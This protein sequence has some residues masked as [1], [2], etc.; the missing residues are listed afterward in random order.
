MC[1]V[2]IPV[3]V[4]F[5]YQSSRVSMLTLNAVS[6]LSK[7][8]HVVAAVEVSLAETSFTTVAKQRNNREITD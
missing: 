3:V 6:S 2:V 7:R 8:L 5:R 4:S 1:S